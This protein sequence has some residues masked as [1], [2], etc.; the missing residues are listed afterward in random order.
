MM[1]KPKTKNTK[2]PAESSGFLKR[3]LLAAKGLQESEIR[4]FLSTARAFGPHVERGENVPLLTGKTIV[5]LFFENSTRTRTSFEFATRRL[6]GNV[7]NF[8]A[9]TSSVQKG[10]TLI[11]TARNIE[12]MKPHCLVVRHSSA[13]SPQFLANSTGM[14]VMVK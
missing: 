5:N 4:Y 3:G 12:A 8:A 6:S 10:E 2:H 11:D 13:G 7:M 9:S 14:P 1:T